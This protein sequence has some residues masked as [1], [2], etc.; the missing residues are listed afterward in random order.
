MSIEEAIGMSAEQ[1]SLMTDSELEKHFNHYLIVTRPE[2]QPKQ[3]KEQQQ[4]LA[5]NP[6]FE[7]A[8]ALAATMG[9]AIPVFSKMKGRK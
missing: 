2:S 1:L 8:R 5:A 6:Q 9:I 7:K 3:I 4:V